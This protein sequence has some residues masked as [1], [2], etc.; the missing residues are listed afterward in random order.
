M[1]GTRLEQIN[2]LLGFVLISF[3]RV[4]AISNFSNYDSTKNTL[5]LDND[6]RGRVF[7]FLLA[8]VKVLPPP[9]SSYSEA[10][11]S[12]PAISISKE[13]RQDRL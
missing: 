13:F 10:L 3:V 11:H 5:P 9:H 2:G 12:S 8:L 4:R 7:T 1:S 6:A